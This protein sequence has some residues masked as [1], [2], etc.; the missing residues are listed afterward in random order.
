MRRSE[1]LRASR[2]LLPPPPF[3]PPCTQPSQSLVN[4]RTKIARGKSFGR[5]AHIIK[6]MAEGLGVT[7]AELLG[8]APAARPASDP[9][10]ALYKRIAELELENRAL[11]RRLA[12]IE[13][14][15][16]KK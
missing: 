2:H 12:A 3:H 6:L 11:R 5:V 13:K 4:R 9:V 1:R 8:Q 15:F 7:E 10:A 16:G 14:T